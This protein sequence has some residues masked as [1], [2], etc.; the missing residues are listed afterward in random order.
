MSSSRQMTQAWIIAASA[1]ESCG[2][3]ASGGGRVGDRGHAHGLAGLEAG[4]GLHPAAV[5]ADFALAAHALDAALGH[6]RVVAAQPAVEALV[7]LLAADG[8]LLD[9]AHAAFKGPRRAPLSRRGSPSS[10]ARAAA[11]ACRKRRLAG[12]G[13]GA[14]DGAGPRSKP[15]T[16]QAA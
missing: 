10:S 6:L 12:M 1:S 5:D 7:R 15:C 3:A 9:A 13:R 14:S 11:R 16:V 2:S 4:R 8:D